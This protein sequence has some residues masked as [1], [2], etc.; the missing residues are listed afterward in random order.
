VRRVSFAAEGDICEVE[1]EEGHSG[2]RRI[3]QACAVLMIVSAVVSELAKSF[4]LNL[5]LLR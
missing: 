3:A 5:V 4:K 2:R 1:P